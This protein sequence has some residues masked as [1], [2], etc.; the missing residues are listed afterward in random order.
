MLFLEESNDHLSQLTSRTG[1]FVHIG[2][3]QYMHKMCVL[4]F[5]IQI[6]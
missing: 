5:I 3:K 2:P 4:F 1:T 6:S